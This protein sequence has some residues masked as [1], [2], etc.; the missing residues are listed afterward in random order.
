MWVPHVSLLRH[1]G[2]CGNHTNLGEIVIPSEARSA[3]PRD[4]L[5]YS[6]CRNPGCPILRAANGGLRGGQPAIMSF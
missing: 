6:T 1:G 5:F 3:K 4:L 2:R